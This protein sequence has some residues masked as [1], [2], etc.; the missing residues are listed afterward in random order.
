MCI[1]KEKTVKIMSAEDFVKQPFVKLSAKHQ[2]NT[3]GIDKPHAD[4]SRTR[5][6]ET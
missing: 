6:F 4:E 3:Y 1:K 5:D 2:G